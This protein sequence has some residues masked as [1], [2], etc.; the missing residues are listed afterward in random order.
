[1]ENRIRRAVIMAEGVKITPR[2]LELETLLDR[3]EPK[4]LKDAREEVEREIVQE[5]LHRNNGN[6]TRAA[7]ELGVSRPT[8]YELLD[9]LGISKGEKGGPE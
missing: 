1:M 4:T 6:M 3:Q 8:L 9:K 7:E 5:A 2:D